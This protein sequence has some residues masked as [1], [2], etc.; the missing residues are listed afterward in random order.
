MKKLLKI[1][2]FIIIFILLLSFF[3][4]LF[5]P[6]GTFKEWYQSNGVLELYYQ[7]KDSIDVLFLG[8]SSVYSGV[9]PL[10]I[11]E[12][13]GVTGFSYSTPNQKVWSSY[14]FLK[15]AQKSQKPKLVFLETG[16]FWVSSKSQTGLGI[17][18]AIDSL[19]F[20]KN[21]I[22]MINDSD[23]NLSNYE[24]LE[25]IFPALRYHSR[26]S[27]LD[28]FDI[29]K[30]IQKN[31]GTYKGFILGKNIQ[32]YEGNKN[33]EKKQ[34]DINITNEDATNN[35]LNQNELN[36]ANRAKREKNSNA[37]LNNK[38]DKN[39]EEQ[40]DTFPDEVKDKL[41][42]IKQLCDSNNCELVLFSMPTPI[43]W[44]E[45]KSKEISSY[46]KEKNIKFVDLNIDSKIQ[47]DWNEDYQDAGYHL[48]IYGAQKVG[49]FLANYIKDNWNLED[50]RKDDK[51]AKWNEILKDYDVYKNDN[52][53][54]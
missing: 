3:D 16:E 35:N 47:I 14:Y 17:R 49:K 26:W 27:Q 24:K 4:K 22:D 31:Q 12:P 23:Y 21:K 53:K 28:E 48:N 45:E 10:E 34:D 40:G 51:Y 13:I 43:D 33:K 46:A 38:K 36:N 6:T 5:N 29:R 32:K 7:P 39:L 19:K 18:R 52:K 54:Q 42:K 30:F 37:D 15:E 25:S 44:S 8:D 9:S 20:S 2:L 41:D 11:Y 1:T 50:H